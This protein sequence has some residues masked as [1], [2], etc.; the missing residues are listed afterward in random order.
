M[1]VTVHGRPL[2]PHTHR[3]NGLGEA[4]ATCSSC[5]RA[6]EPTSGRPKEGGVCIQRTRGT[7]DVPDFATQDVCQGLDL[8]GRPRPS[9]GHLV[10]PVRAEVV[11][12][13]ADLRAE[14][15]FWA[16]RLD[17]H[18]SVDDTFHTVIDAAGEW[19]IGVQ[20]APQ[21]T[22]PDWPNGA[23]QQVHLDLHV[24][25][26]VKAHEQAMN[27]A[28]VCSNP[29]TWLA[30]RGTRYTPTRPAIRSASAGVTQPTKLW[31]HSSRRDS[32]RRAHTPSAASKA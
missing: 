28:P 3:P 6:I 13:A 31:P 17:G 20:L 32:G 19:R 22:P 2:G 11:F 4:L 16:G 12:D 29:M 1:S 15:T 7:A 26:P 14:S 5:P 27:S 24:D 25:D 18:V 23:P 8:A 21:H 9:Y 10:N 30:K